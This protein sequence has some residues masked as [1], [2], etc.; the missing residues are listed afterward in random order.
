M[1][2]SKLKIRYYYEK[3]GEKPQ[4]FWC[5]NAGLQLNTAPW[6]Q[7]IADE[8]KGTF[9]DDY[10]EITFVTDK[11]VDNNG[12]VLNMGIRFAQSDWSAYIGLKEIGLKVYY[13]GVLLTE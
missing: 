4:N 3:E 6:Y 8:V 1:D 7:N 10:L 11:Q 9:F 13:D 2:L 5:D 12:S